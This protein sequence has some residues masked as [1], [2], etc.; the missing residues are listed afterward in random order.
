MMAEILGGYASSIKP[1]RYE[2]L[3]QKKII[4][5]LNR[6]AQEQWNH[7]MLLQNLLAQKL[8]K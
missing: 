5:A 2:D 8:K 1:D 7:S 4:L 6:K 3:K